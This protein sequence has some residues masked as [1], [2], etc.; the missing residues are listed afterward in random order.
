[1][2]KL[3]KETRELSESLHNSLD[4][5]QGNIECAVS[6]YNEAI[7]AFHKLQGEVVGESDHTLER[8]KITFLRLFPKD[9][10]GCS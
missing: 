7:L 10:Y 9:G 4:E 6:A 3:S 5:L 8:S 2:I 1:M